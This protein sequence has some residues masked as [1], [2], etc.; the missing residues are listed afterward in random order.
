M[1]DYEIWIILEKEL[2]INYNKSSIE[3]DKK[4][5]K[6]FINNKL[7]WFS[8]LKQLTGKIR[9]NKSENYIF[10]NHF[11]IIEKNKWNGRKVFEFI[12]NLFN[13]DLFELYPTMESIKFWNKIEKE[14]DSTFIM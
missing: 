11:E 4:Y 14:T 3:F 2:P 10:I 1:I 6:F 13:V 9:K 5:Y 8:L 12:K 7:I